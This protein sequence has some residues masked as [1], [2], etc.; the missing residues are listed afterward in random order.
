MK[1]V[2][3]FLTV[4]FLGIL[5]FSACSDDDENI[6][7]PPDASNFMPLKVGAY[8]VYESYK[9]ENE[10]E[11]VTGVD[12]MTV[13]NSYQDGEDIIYEIAKS[14]GYLFKNIIPDRYRVSNGIIYAEG[15]LFSPTLDISQSNEIVYTDTMPAD[16]G[17]IDYFFYDELTTVETPAGIFDCINVQGKI[18]ST[19]TDEPIHNKLIN[20]YYAEG[21]GLVRFNN[22]WWNSASEIGFRLKSYEIP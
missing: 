2:L 9:V 5:L 7:P 18:T 8:W 16:L 17:Y 22:Y 14:D 21:I 3:P 13:V 10:E 15:D 19:D 1:T 20:N 6:V 11:V 12:T 4:L